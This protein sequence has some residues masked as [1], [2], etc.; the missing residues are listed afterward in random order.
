MISFI[1]KYTG[2]TEVLF[3]L[4]RVVIQSN[5]C[6]KTSWNEDSSTKLVL[7]WLQ[8][9]G[10]KYYVRNATISSDDEKQDL[11]KLSFIY[12]LDFT[13]EWCSVL[14]AHET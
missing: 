7:K 1:D 3:Q 14:I 2:W 11:E 4:G 12:N 8:K 6:Q 13:C 10:G 5:V 9:Y